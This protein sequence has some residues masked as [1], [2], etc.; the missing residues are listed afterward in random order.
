M[1]HGVTSGSNI[2]NQGK[3]CDPEGVIHC[4]YDKECGHWK[5]NPAHKRKALPVVR[6]LPEGADGEQAEQDETGLFDHQAYSLCAGQAKK[7]ERKSLRWW[8]C[9]EEGTS[10]QCD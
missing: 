6:H 7:G 5:D 4:N 3:S 10:E 8:Q 1:R 2:F 9:A